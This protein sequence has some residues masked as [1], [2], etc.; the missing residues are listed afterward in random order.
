ML[1]SETV[2]SPDSMAALLA[3]LKASVRRPVASGDNDS[4]VL[5]KTTKTTKT[6]EKT[7]GFALVAAKMYYFGVGGGTRD[8]VQLLAADGAFACEVL[9]GQRGVFGICECWLFYLF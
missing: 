5:E 9:S 7:G 2:Y 1:T 8:F 3:L 6:T 4:V